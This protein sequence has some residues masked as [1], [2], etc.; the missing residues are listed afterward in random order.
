MTTNSCI[1]YAITYKNCTTIMTKLPR[2]SANAK[3]ISVRIS[4]SLL[5]RSG[6]KA[7]GSSPKR[8]SAQRTIPDAPSPAEGGVACQG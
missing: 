5:Q 1:S 2:G 4:S 3:D 7:I 8:K 6:V